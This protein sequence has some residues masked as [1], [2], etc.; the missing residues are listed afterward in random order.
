MHTPATKT[1]NKHHGTTSG[2]TTF[3]KTIHI[4]TYMAQERTSVRERQNTRYKEPQRYKVIMFN[5]DFT[6]MDFV[7][8][9]LEEIFFKTDAEAEQLMLKVHHEEKAVIGIYSYD[10]AKSK[11]EKAMEKARKEKYPLKLTYMPV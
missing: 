10:I 7:V 1:A 9:V 8:E 3:Y 2:R 5:D 4:Y 6:P 11:T